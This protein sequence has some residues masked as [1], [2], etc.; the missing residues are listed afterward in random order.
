MQE[1]DGT[2]EPQPPANLREIPQGQPH[3]ILVVDDH[4]VV[5]KGLAM[6]LAREPDMMV[7]GEAE[8]LE[9]ALAAIIGQQ[10]DLL[11]AD[12][13]LDGMNGMELIREVRRLHPRLPVLVLSMHDEDVYAERA[14]R[15]GAK[16]YLMKNVKPEV[17]VSGIR[18][19]LKGE[20]VVTD[21][22]KSRIIG[23]LAGV[24][25]DRPGLSLDRLTDRELEIFGMIGKGNTI[26]RI[27]EKLSLS[28]KT[29]EAHCAH[30]KQK[31]GL[32]SGAELQYMAFGALRIPAK[33]QDQLSGPPR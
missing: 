24:R 5:R 13:E 2:M 6:T 22:I 18:T 33:D 19:V 12:L 27:S 15:S 29:I 20:I 4:P 28:I 21:R 23:N 31:L 25:E 32:S 30:I 26:R 16:G 14:L 8:G 10:P 9:E 11:L 1:Y 17:L 7:C 3:R